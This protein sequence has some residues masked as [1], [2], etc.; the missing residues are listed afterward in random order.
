[1]SGRAP[2]CDELLLFCRQLVA[3]AQSSAVDF[4][5]HQQEEFME[6]EADVQRR[7]SR[8][9]VAAVT[10]DARLSPILLQYCGWSKTQGF[11]PNLSVAPEAMQK[12]VDVLASW[13]P[14]ATVAERTLNINKLTQV[15]AFPAPPAS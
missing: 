7:F 15:Y 14:F 2:A 1:M 11:V 9:A 13:I 5:T 6:S 10:E 4:D 12:F 8:K 3:E